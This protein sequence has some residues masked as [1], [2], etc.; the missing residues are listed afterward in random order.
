M[1]R[2]TM[3]IYLEGANELLAEMEEAILH[4]GDDPDEMGEINRLFRVMHS[5]KG[6]SAMVELNDV[7]EFAH[8][9]ESECDYFRQ[10]KARVSSE[11]LKL[12]LKSHDQ[13]KILIFSHFG[14]VKADHKV[15]EY[16]INE[17]KKFR[18]GSV[19]SSFSF[20]KE[21]LRLIRLLTSIQD[22]IKHLKQISFDEVVKISKDLS[23]FLL[24]SRRLQKESLTEFMVP[25]E[26]FLRTCK[27]LAIIPPDEFAEFLRDVLAEAS[28]LLNESDVQINEADFSPEALL[29]SLQIPMELKDR[30]KRIKLSIDFPDARLP[31]EKEYLIRLDQ[32]AE[33]MKIF[34]PQTIIDALSLLGS[35]TQKSDIN[36]Q[37]ENGA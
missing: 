31:D 21:E 36:S 2:E 26:S 6:S 4:L 14:G 23:C 25:F 33:N 32:I 22:S 16:L 30:L 29:R 34:N 11:F 19:A 18:S 9:L 20:E 17:I 10:G 1:D 35:V 37:K 13:I 12:V 27:K 15:S 3:S 7:S 24:L 8:K 5:L 28:R